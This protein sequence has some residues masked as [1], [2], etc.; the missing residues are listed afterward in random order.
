[1]HD[2]ACDMTGTNSHT[3]YVVCAETS[4]SSTMCASETSATTPFNEASSE[5]PPTNEVSTEKTETTT[6]T[7][8]ATTLPPPQGLIADVNGDCHCL[9]DMNVTTTTQTEAAI[10]CSDFGGQ[11]PE[12]ETLFDLNLIHSTGTYSGVFDADTVWMAATRSSG[13]HFYVHTVFV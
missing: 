4:C 3:F 8:T 5:N 7:D 12:A 2:L 10:R 6:E 11:L 13:S 9:Y 1:M